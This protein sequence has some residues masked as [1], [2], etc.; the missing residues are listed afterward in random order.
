MNDLHSIVHL[1]LTYPSETGQE[2]TYKDPV[3]VE[4]TSG[5]GS[6]LKLAIAA[7]IYDTIGTDLV[8]MCANEVVCSGAQPFAFLDY[9]A[10]GKLFVPVVAQ[11]VKGIS[12]GCREVNSVLLGGET[13]EMPSLFAPGSYDLAGYSVGCVEYGNELPRLN[14]ITD[15]DLVIGL[16]SNGLH[17]AGFDLIYDVIKRNEINLNE[18]APFSPSKLSYGQEFLRP[19]FL[20]AA[21]V[22]PLIYS[23]A[24]KAAAHIT[25]G[26]LLKNVARIVPKNFSADLDAE[27]WNVLPIYGWL[28]AKTDLSVATITQNFNC[29]I[30]F[31]FVISANN[32]EWK[33]IPGAVAI[34]RIV[35]NS[36]GNRQTVSIRNISTVLSKVSADFG[37]PTAIKRD[38]LNQNMTKE[39]LID[40]FND[41]VNSTLKEQ[42][43]RQHH[44]NRLIRLHP[45]GVAKYQDPILVIGTDGV[46][47]KL[48]IAQIIGKHDT[49]GIDLVAMCVNDTLCNGA[50]PL[51]FLDYYACGKYH[52][53]V[54]V[55]V[56]G[57]VADGCDQSSSSLI[58]GKSVEVPLLYHDDEYDLAGF[59]LGV[60]EH[61]NL[62]P[63]TDDIAVGDVIIGLPSSGVHSNGFSLVH[64]VMEVA[65][66]TFHDRAP[67]SATGKS[68]GEELLTPTK[69][70]T[71]IIKSLLSTRKIK[72]IA[73]ITGGG[74]LEN[75]P[76]VLRNEL[77]V[78]LDATQ[79]NIPPVFAWLAATGNI[80]NRE[81]QRT[82]NCGIGLVLVVDP[83]DV[84]FILSELKWSDGAHVLG[85]VQP[86]V[87]SDPQVVINDADFTVNLQRVQRVL[88]EPKKRVGVLV[89]ATGGKLQAL[90]DSTK[91]STYGSG[92]EIAVVISN[93]ADALGLKR[94]EAAGIPTKVISHLD[95]KL[96]AD[97]RAAFDQAVTAEL[98]VHGVDIVCLASFYRIVSPSFVHRWN[99]KLI[100]THPSLLPKYPGMWA[101]RQVLEAQPRERYTGCTIHFVDEGVDT[102]EIIWQEPVPILENDTEDS[103]TQR[104]HQAEFYAFPRVL[105]GLATG[106]TAHKI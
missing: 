96:A 74:L 49:V 25:N 104:I 22:L 29:G 82:Y 15:G 14:D 38:V 89:S 12:E 51:T 21:S 72:A 103:L 19:S 5:I 16:P 17:C 32:A 66:F 41:I 85:T 84:E 47:T 88:R 42:H 76:R 100:N 7:G 45:N 8:A 59:A 102:G 9:V 28:L 43:V 68:F 56:V 13:A 77:A 101:Q 10:C 3:L 67:F 64:K 39:R 31:A 55:D 94:A 65:G 52:T 106:T 98:E 105:R 60:A 97:P 63:R 33:N 78:H 2:T 71:D 6:K 58:N 83:N 70:Y 91:D 40:A 11:I 26:G 1:Q 90:I 75:I 23:G 18:T 79:M 92:A 46:G 80:S 30:G 95:F 81:L 62:L 50:E 36:T 44:N 61:A 54:A 87:E 24:I 20:Y 93:K 34:G 35:Q 99:G 53:Q 86:R 37:A 57:G 69:I 73:H 4:K 27:L 48:K